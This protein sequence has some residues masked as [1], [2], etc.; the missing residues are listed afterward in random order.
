MTDS[1]NPGDSFVPLT[2]PKDVAVGARR[3][4]LVGSCRGERSLLESR[5]SYAQGYGVMAVVDFR[6]SA[7]VDGIP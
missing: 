7:G 3:N 1:R 2:G 6:G 5:A 4:V